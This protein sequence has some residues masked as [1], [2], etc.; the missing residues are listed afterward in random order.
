MA[1]EEL[2]WLASEAISEVRFVDMPVVQPETFPVETNGS[3][4]EQYERVSLYAGGT[5]LT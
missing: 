5:L 1:A 4:T 2:L 3:S